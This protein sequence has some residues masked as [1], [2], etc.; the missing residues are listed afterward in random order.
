ML[1]FAACCLPYCAHVAAGH[2]PC[3]SGRVAGRRKPY[4]LPRPMSCAGG[5]TS[6][7]PAALPSHVVPRSASVPQSQVSTPGRHFAP[8][9]PQANAATTTSGLPR[10][11]LRGTLAGSIFGADWLTRSQGWKTPLGCP[12]SVATISRAGLLRARGWREHGAAGHAALRGRCL[13]SLESRWSFASHLTRN[14]IRQ[15][16]PHDSRASLFYQTSPPPVVTIDS[17]RFDRA[18]YIGAFYRL[19]YRPGLFYGACNIP[20]FYQILI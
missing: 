13:A 16:R 4:A 15:R 5:N 14:M 6:L 17:C 12:A 19:R 10:D 3:S 7:P 18:V 2:P 20:S 9:A 11:D 8:R 1:R